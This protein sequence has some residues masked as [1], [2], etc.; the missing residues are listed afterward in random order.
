MEEKKIQFCY[1]CGRKIEDDYHYCPRCGILVRP[2]TPT[3]QEILPFVLET[4]SHLQMDLSI[5]RNE[6]ENA[7]LEEA[8]NRLTRIIEK[9]KKCPTSFLYEILRILLSTGKFMEAESR[10]KR[11]EIFLT[12][13]HLSLQKDVVMKLKEQWENLMKNYK[14]KREFAEFREQFHALFPFSPLSYD[15]LL[16]K[17]NGMIH[18]SYTSNN[19]L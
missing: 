13:S 4:P 1:H 18:P 2:F 9:E 17:I 7:Q 10:M 16:E 5:A 12:K 3:S 6:I 8:M 14:E 15:L 11:Y 19:G